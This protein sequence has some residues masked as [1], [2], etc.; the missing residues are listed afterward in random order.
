MKE[1]F[2]FIFLDFWHFLGTL[3][4]TGTILRGL[5]FIIHGYPKKEPK[6]KEKKEN[7]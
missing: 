1:I 4:L 6:E 5:G 3:V 7:L 2:E